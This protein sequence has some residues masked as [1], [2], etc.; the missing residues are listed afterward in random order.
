MADVYTD[1]SRVLY[2]YGSA[3]IFLVREHGAMLRPTLN[4]AE[5]LDGEIEDDEDAGVPN[6]A[7]CAA[8]TNADADGS[9]DVEEGAEGRV[10][11]MLMRFICGF[12]QGCPFSTFLAILPMHM[13]LQEAHDAYPDLRTASL[14][15]D[16][17]FG[18]LAAVFGPA[19][20]LVRKLHKER[21]N[22]KSNTSKLKAFVPAGGV[23]GV[24][25]LFLE[26]QGGEILGQVCRRLCRS[27][28]AQIGRVEDRPAHQNPYRASRAA[29]PD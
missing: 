9:V 15:D 28:R 12:M 14:A 27:R 6:S 26:A 21:C 29:R 19:F 11:Q 16:N 23:E 2:G 1:L 18:A 3:R 13:A 22:L 7:A 10:I 25:K 17:Y 20:E 24:P 4:L 5:L 8:T